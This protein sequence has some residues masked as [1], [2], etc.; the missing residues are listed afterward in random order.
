MKRIA[1]TAL[2]AMLLPAAVF[3]QEVARTAYRGAE[4]QKTIPSA[5]SPYGDDVR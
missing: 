3:A 5:T 2:L 1:I 4:P